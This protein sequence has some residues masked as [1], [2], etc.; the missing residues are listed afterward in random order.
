M[1]E[2]AVIGSRCL[3]AVLHFEDHP[4]LS[5]TDVWLVL[6]L[7]APATG[8]QSLPF[9]LL[10]ARVLL[11]VFLVSSAMSVCDSLRKRVLS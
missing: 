4:R 5:R 6:L 7:Q 3:D 9:F 11:I 1:L 8:A 10:V 2:R